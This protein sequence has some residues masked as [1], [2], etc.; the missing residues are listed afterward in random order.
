MPR[1]RI[2][3]SQPKKTISQKKGID[4]KYKRPFGYKPNGN[5]FVGDYEFT[6]EIIEELKDY[7]ASGVSLGSLCVVVDC[8]YDDF[9]F[10]CNEFP[11]LSRAV[12][13]A[14][15]R[16]NIQVA[17]SLAQSALSGDVR[18]QQFFLKNRD[19]V[20][21]ECWSDKSQEELEADRL[22]RNPPKLVIALS[23]DEDS[24]ITT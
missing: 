1:K 7:A 22:G 5:P 9:Q 18:A 15:A 16:T 20:S 19:G 23:Q 14:R 17:R 21:R 4:V 12:Y 24:Q 2:T 8:S 10:G 6:P 13:G 3:T 11:E